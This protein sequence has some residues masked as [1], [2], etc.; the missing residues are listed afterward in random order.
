MRRRRAD[1]RRSAEGC[2][3]S[4]HRRWVSRNGRSTHHQ[5][6]LFAVQKR[7]QKP[8]P[9]PPSLLAPH[10]SQ[11]QRSRSVRAS[12]RYCGRAYG[13]TGRFP[14]VDV[15]QIVQRG[16][17]AGFWMGSCQILPT[18]RAILILA[19]WG[20]FRPRRNDDATVRT[21][22]RRRIVSS[23]AA[24]EDSELVAERQTTR[25]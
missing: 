12:R 17:Q 16:I 25:L 24:H 14:P 15:G 6:W 20:W 8:R 3:D 2:G 21:D 13:H 4:S 10:D 19:Q 7:R 22:D 5:G 18:G 9:L 23:L 1:G 11:A